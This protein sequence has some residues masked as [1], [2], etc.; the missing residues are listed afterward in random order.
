MPSVFMD[1]YDSNFIYF[2]SLTTTLCS[3]RALHFNGQKL[4]ASRKTELEEIVR[5]FYGV[6]SI[7]EELLL[8]AIDVDP[9]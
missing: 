2:N 9:K 8:L 6:D 1:E 4:P 3:S 7:S 5:S